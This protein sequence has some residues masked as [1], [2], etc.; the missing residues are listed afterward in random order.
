MGGRQ[1]GP[2]RARS[3]ALSSCTS[4]PFRA[5]AR[6]AASASVEENANERRDRTRFAWPAALGALAPEDGISYPARSDTTRRGARA[7][8]WAGLEN[9]DPAKPR[10]IPR[11]FMRRH[12]LCPYQPLPAGVVADLPGGK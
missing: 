10:E 3:L 4:R 7:A 2:G 5:V 11:F 9:F 12:P 8:D 1:R 6:G